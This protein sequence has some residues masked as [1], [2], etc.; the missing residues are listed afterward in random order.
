MSDAR[1]RGRKPQKKLTRART[2]LT[3]MFNRDG[4]LPE[5]KAAMKLLV[6]RLDVT[7]AQAS[8]Y[9]NTVRKEIAA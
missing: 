5:R 4:A 7:S 8:T 6:R 3:N 1:T 2:I 9:F